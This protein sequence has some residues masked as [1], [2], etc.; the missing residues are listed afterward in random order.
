MDIAALKKM[1]QDTLSPLKFPNGERL[2]RLMHVS[3][4]APML[5]LNYFTNTAVTER[6]PDVSLE[7]MISSALDN[8]T[9]LTDS[10]VDVEL[11][12]QNALKYGWEHPWA[13]TAYDK[14]PTVVAVESADDGHVIALVCYDPHLNNS[15]VEIASK[16]VELEQIPFGKGQPV[17]LTPGESL[18]GLVFDHE[19][20]APS[21]NALF[22]IVPRSAAGQCG[23]LIYRNHEWHSGIS[24]IGRE[25]DV[26]PVADH[27]PVP[28]SK[29]KRSS[30]PTL[31]LKQFSDAPVK[32]SFTELAAAFSAMNSSK[33]PEY[34]HA[35][36]HPAVQALCQQWNAANPD[37]PAAGAFRVYIWDEAI[38]MF[39]AG[40]P[41][42]PNW[43]P[44][45]FSDYMKS[46]ATYYAPYTQKLAVVIFTTP[47]A[48][49]PETDRHCVKVKTVCGE[50][51]F[52]VGAGP[53]EY[54]EAYYA[55]SGLRSL[56]GRYCA[57]PILHQ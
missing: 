33:K 10:D 29:E 16:Y 27:S 38:G 12:Y 22:E 20:S 45:F 41:E 52:E 39:V 21:L 7:N 31:P 56:Y 34:M 48:T 3:G 13:E 24:N 18:H 17:S 28:V 26:S 36:S 55:W 5:T 8:I 19:L 53:D 11:N 46:V 30:R 1:I 42:E 4:D 54:D 50:V 43:K 25:L 47:R 2:I 44:E 23:L 32:G 37:K 15:T 35:E 40:D 49:W 57:T 51:L 6:N 14:F 9:A